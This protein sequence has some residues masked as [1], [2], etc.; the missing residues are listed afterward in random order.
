MASLLSTLSVVSFIL[1]GLFA[2]L[3]VVFGF[4]FKI[5]AVIGD[6]SGRTAK[7][8]VERMRLENEREKAKTN[9]GVKKSKTEKLN[10]D[11]YMRPLEDGK[12]S[13]NKNKIKKNLNKKNLN[14]KN[15]KV[16]EELET[17]LLYESFENSREYINNPDEETAILGSSYV[18]ENE[19]TAIL[20]NS[21]ISEDEETGILESS[22]V[23]D[24]DETGILE[25][26]YISEGDATAVLNAPNRTEDEEIDNKQNRS[27]VKIEIMDEIKLIHTNET[28]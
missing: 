23:S 24:D 5:M 2:L 14:R 8:T 4:V 18:S 17:G 10:V 27:T 9:D 15:S 13:K 21:Y 6:L 12:S 26:S 20:G 28:I 3:A 16:E 25:S 7:K 19:E 11:K 22:Y 1:S